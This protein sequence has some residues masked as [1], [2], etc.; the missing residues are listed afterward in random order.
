MN[1]KFE[2]KDTVVFLSILHTTAYGIT[3]QHHD[4]V[5]IYKIETNNNE[6]LHEIK[7]LKLS[8]IS[9]Y[10]MPLPWKPYYRAVLDEDGNYIYDEDGDELYEVKYNTIEE[11]FDNLN[12]LNKDYKEWKEYV[13]E[14]F[15]EFDKLSY[16]KSKEFL[17]LTDYEIPKYWG[18]ILLNKK[19]LKYLP[20]Q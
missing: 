16:E 19:Y 12:M 9:A 11:V 15:N 18:D 13:F 6:L 14:F 17:K 2:N 20:K 4:Y 3:Q 1:V 5:Q 8:P 10:E 7:S